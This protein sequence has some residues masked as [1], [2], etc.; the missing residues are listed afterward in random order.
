M[1]K[2]LHFFSRKDTNCTQS[3]VNQTVVPSSFTSDSKCLHS[4]VSWAHQH[5]EACRSL[6]AL[7]EVLEGHCWGSVKAVWGCMDGHSYAMDAR[8]AGDLGIIT[9][10]SRPLG[11][12]N[13]D[14]LMSEEDE[15]EQEQRLQH[16]QE[17]EGEDEEEQLIR[18]GKIP[19][20]SM[21]GPAL[22]AAQTQ[23]SALPEWSSSTQG[24]SWNQTCRTEHL[25]FSPQVCRFEWIRCQSFSMTHLCFLV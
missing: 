7:K 23:S 15:V 12:N 20:G 25:L 19:G 6:P 13:C 2:Y 18:N 17:E 11:G 16:Q 5:G 22:V 21:T 14:D 8:C 10:L 24:E 3:S 4:L 1:L 9:N